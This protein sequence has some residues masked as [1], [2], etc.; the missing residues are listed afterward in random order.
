[1]SDPFDFKPADVVRDDM[2][3]ITHDVQHMLADLHQRVRD[4]LQDSPGDVREAY[5]ASKRKWDNASAKM[6]EALVRAE[7]SGGFTAQ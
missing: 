3:A 1:V 6:S 2:C 5:E 7:Q 4:G